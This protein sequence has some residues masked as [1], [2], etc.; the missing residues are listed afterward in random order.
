MENY[1]SEKIIFTAPSGAI[2]ASLMSTSNSTAELA[3]VLPGAGYPCT[4]PLLYYS[5]DALLLKGYQVLAIEKVYGDDVAWRGFQ[6]R[7]AAFK[8]VEDD[9]LELFAQISKMFSERVK[10]LLGR[11]LG[12]YQMACAL[13]KKIVQPRQVVWQTPSLYEKWSV[14]K[15]SGVAGFGIIGTLDP[16]YGT[17]L[18][19]FP[20]DRIVVDG[21]DHAMEVPGN[22]ARSIEVL[23]EVIRATDEWLLSAES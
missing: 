15:D 23:G 11:S 4:M 16:R 8:Y 18:P 7:E 2:N 9:T 21:A 5:I 10:I 3:V 17:A 1:K 13:E 19:Y 14:I 22:V 12:T 6:T 20:Q